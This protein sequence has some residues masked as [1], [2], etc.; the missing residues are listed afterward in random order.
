MVLRKIYRM[1]SNEVLCG[2]ECGHKSKQS[3]T[4]NKIHN[5]ILQTFLRILFIRYQF[6]HFKGAVINGVKEIHFY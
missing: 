6:M 5:S 1:V 3:I 2:S 4:G